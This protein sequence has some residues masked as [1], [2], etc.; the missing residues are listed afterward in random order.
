MKVYQ[1]VT[2]VEESTIEFNTSIEDSFS[3]FSI[4]AG[5]GNA[6]GDGLLNTGFVFSG[7]EGYIFDQ[8]GRFVGGYESKEVFNILVHCKSNNTM[9]FFINDV[10]IAN[11]YS[12]LTGFDYIEFDKH[13]ESSMNITHSY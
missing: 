3:G 1:N 9:S 7:S 11:N 13:G 2:G 10:L 4:A 8:S 6:G 12:A 5:T